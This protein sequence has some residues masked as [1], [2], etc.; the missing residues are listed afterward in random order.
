MVK[1]GLLALLATVVLAV[2][3]VSHPQAKQQPF[4]ANSH[5]HYSGSDTIC[6]TDSAGSK[7]CYP[8]VFQATE[9]FQ[10][11]MPGQSVPPGL[12]VQIDM[13]TG[14]RMAKLMPPGESN[15]GDSAEHGALTVVENDE[16][17]DNGQIAIGKHSNHQADSSLEA[18]ISRLVTA[19]SNPGSVA[20][21]THV[22]QAL[23]KLEELV[24]D[25]RHASALL[26]DT[27]AVP[28]LLRLSDPKPV[29]Q[30]MPQ[31]S[32]PPVVRQL[33]SVV[34]GSAVQNNQK[35]QGVAMQSGAV[36]HLL[37]FLKSETNLK[38]LGKHIFAL[39]AVIRG[40]SLALEQF[41]QHGGF[42]TLRDVHPFALSTSQENNE[43]EASKLESRLVRFVDDLFNP[44][45]N[46]NPTS[47][48]AVLIR[49]GA[50]V[51]CNAL[52]SRLINNLEDIDDVHETA[53]PA[54]QRKLDY[55]R[56][57]QSLKTA[58]PDK[59]VLPLE[60][61]AW[62]QDEHASLLSLSDVDGIE[63]YRHA[64]NELDY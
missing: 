48:A 7:S 61:K 30:G 10:V 55:A 43:V 17:G 4:M 44:E 9:E 5:D 19:T 11:I 49:E 45:F 24:H 51:W 3:V 27:D 29:H 36:T 60:L 56:V 47:E 14:Q 23:G 40:H 8:K 37:S 28:T 16:L 64:L 58:Y 31:Q 25:T 21:S 6:T 53:V 54:F 32:W 46:P 57:L 50:L 2:P 35:L 34:L 41:A 15:H 39:S 59:C 42:Q 62:L 52:A 12:H 13:T 1:I 33:S 38:A 18:H 22:V 26:H 63:E 20:D